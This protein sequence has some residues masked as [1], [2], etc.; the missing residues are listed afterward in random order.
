[1]PARNDGEA[2]LAERSNLNVQASAIQHRPELSSSRPTQIATAPC[3]WIDRTSHFSVTSRPSS[4]VRYQG[5]IATSY[6]LAAQPPCAAVAT[7]RAHRRRHNSRKT[8]A[9]SGPAT[10]TRAFGDT[11]ANMTRFSEM[12]RIGATSSA[13]AAREKELSMCPPHAARRN[14][15]IIICEAGGATV[16]G[17][18]LISSSS[19]PGTMMM[20]CGRRPLSNIANLMAWVRSTNRPPRLPH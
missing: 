2:V 13:C 12:R 17:P 8:T 10:R 14:G 11:R 20:A 7:T 1:M 6:C 19:T 16:F 18:P 9:L 5:T 4:G 15:V 3:L